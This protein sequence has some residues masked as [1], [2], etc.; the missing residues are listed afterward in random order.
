VTS[1]NNLLLSPEKVVTLVVNTETPSRAARAHERKLRLSDAILG[2]EVCRLE[3][4]VVGNLRNLVKFE[5]GNLCGD[6][7]KEDEERGEVLHGGR[8]GESGGV[9]STNCGRNEQDSERKWRVTQL[10]CPN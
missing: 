4:R 9:G 7:R 5:F 3:E 10:G 2:S 1:L 8:G 6:E